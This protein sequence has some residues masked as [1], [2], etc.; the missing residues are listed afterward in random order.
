MTDNFDC[1]TSYKLK[2]ESPSDFRPD[3]TQFADIDIKGFELVRKPVTEKNIDKILLRERISGVS[4]ADGGAAA[5]YL[6]INAHEGGDYDFRYAEN[7][8]NVCGK[9][10]I[11][12]EGEIS[13]DNYLK[14]V[15]CRKHWCPECG[16]KGGHIHKSRLHSILN[17]VNAD[18]YNVRQLVFTIP[19]SLRDTFKDREK[20][21]DLFKMTK[22]VIEKRFGE[23]IFD[24]KGHVRKYRLDKPAIAYL[25]AFG[26]EA[27]GV[28]KPHINVHILESKKVLLKLSESY[29]QEIKDDW[30]KKLKKY[31]SSLL[32]VDVNYSFVTHK[33]KIIHK[34]KY[35]S[36]PWSKTDYD[37]IQ[38]ESLKHLLVMDLLG[39]QYLRYWGKLSNRTYKDEMILT[40]IIE[41]AE[42]KVNE[43]LIFRFWALIN[44]ESYKNVLIEID[45]G[46]YRIKKKGRGYESKENQK[47]AESSEVGK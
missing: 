33:G 17:R 10:V 46:F 26:D 3:C 12:F 7:I 44:L 14:R 6:D 38:D 19:E 23:A 31:D 8:P 40:E 24:K 32:V 13:G 29:L 28:F 45:D 9:Q 22:Q 34:F 35:M 36:R 4:F 43:K 5:P 42:V 2:N 37:N 18:F 11:W 21:N 1:V 16:G 20:L 47:D 25:H 15:D 41:E 39:F 30:L 27:P